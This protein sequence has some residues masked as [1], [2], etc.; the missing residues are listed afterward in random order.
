[1]LDNFNQVPHDE[2]IE[3][4]VLGN[5]LVDPHKF[6]LYM[7]KLKED[8]FYDIRHKIIFRGMSE[9]EGERGG[10]PTV[11]TLMHFLS[12]SK[13]DMDGIS[14]LERAG[15]A[16]YLLDITNAVVHS[17]GMEEYIDIL[18]NL[19]MLRKLIDTTDSIKKECY[20]NPHNPV[21]VI[22]EAEK[23]ILEIRK[24][25][26]TGKLLDSEHFAMQV[27][28]N[29]E[30]R[31]RR[32]KE[33]TEEELE[34]PTPFSLL[35]NYTAGGFQPGEMVIL[36][37]RPSVGKTATALNM[38]FHALQNNKPVLFF[39]LEMPAETLL[40]RIIASFTNTPFMKIRR[41][42]LDDDKVKEIKRALDFIATKPLYFVDETTDIMEMR[43]IAR[44][45]HQEL[46]D[47]GGLGLIIVDYIGL[48]TTSMKFESNQYK[49][50]YYSMLLKRLARELNV[51]VLVLSQLN[52]GVEKEKDTEPKLS[53]LRDSGALE[54]DA[55]IV[56]LLHKPKK[57][58][59]ADNVYN[60][61]STYVQERLLIV[62]KN[63]NGAT[64]YIKLLFRPNVQSIAQ[65]EMS[66]VT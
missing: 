66:D 15:G 1:M 37:A 36:A 32:K 28:M 3:R 62:A 51:P 23:K 9:M 20:S 45:Q 34:V 44:R 47:S 29:L 59:N 4:I 13:N 33:G 14:N 53:H 61:D 10:I 8:Y 2:E 5:I 57:D 54:Q 11:H 18:S 6:E 17:H 21:E 39:S 41:G 46:R 48:I 16:T 65:K 40:L 49:I 27:L 42:E 25:K 58:E 56:L 64:G 24:L 38:A 19:A 30:E 12:T 52:R 55:D 7:G 63:R 26:D 60:Q 50:A 31:I 43:A 35:N 22:D